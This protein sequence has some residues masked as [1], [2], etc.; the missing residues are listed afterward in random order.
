MSI[1]FS[2]FSLIKWNVMLPVCQT[3]GDSVFLNDVEKHLAVIVWTFL[4]DA[5]PQPLISPYY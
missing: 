3:M 4:E 2:P 5:P 1:N